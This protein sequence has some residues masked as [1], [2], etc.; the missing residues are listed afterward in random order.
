MGRFIIQLV[1]GRLERV[2]IEYAGDLSSLALNTRYI[3]RYV[4][5]GLMD[6]ILQT[7][8]TIINAD[9][10]AKERGIVVRESITEES[11]GF[12][13]LITLSV[14]TDQ[15]SETM[16]GSVFMKDRIRIVSIGGYTMDMIPEGY[17]I[18][19]RHLDKPGVIGRASTI[20]GEHQ[21]NIAGMQVGRIKPGEEA[22]M[23]LNVDSEV[24]PPVMDLIRK[25]VGIFTATFVKL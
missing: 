15:M 20:L 4:L 11:R 18:V 6:P 16:S 3:T 19:S 21:I 9:Y 2:E 12:K 22:I 24:P 5:K 14:K 13:N 17:V 10:I 1:Q 7:P 8:V 23:V 25:K